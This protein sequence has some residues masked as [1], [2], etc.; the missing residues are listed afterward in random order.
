MKLYNEDCLTALKKL[1]DDSVDCIVTDCPYH[2]VSGGCTNLEQK[3]TGGMLKKTKSGFVSE[4]SKHVSLFGMLNDRDPLTYAKQ[5]KLFKY[6]EIQFEEW[7]PEIYRV[8]K[9]G[10]HIYIYI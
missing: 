1:A 4:N 2:I 6:N 3:Q 9:P 5:G 10:K 8:I 7:L